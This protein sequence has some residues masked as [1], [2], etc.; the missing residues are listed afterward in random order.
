MVPLDVKDYA[1]MDNGLPR[2]TRADQGLEEIILSPF[3]I[4]G[5]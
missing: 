1:G 3:K 4:L 2:V 5:F